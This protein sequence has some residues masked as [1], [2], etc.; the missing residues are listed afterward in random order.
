VVVEASLAGSNHGTIRRPPPEIEAAGSTILAHFSVRDTGI[1]IPKDKHEAVFNAF[2]QADNS[3]S[4]QFGGTGLGLAI[5]S[6]LIGQMGGHIWVESEAGHGSTFHFT[7]QFGVRDATSPSV[8]AAA[9]DKASASVAVVSAPSLP[10]PPLRILLAEDNPVNQELM[11]C[12]LQAH[13][14]NVTIANNG[15]EAVVVAQ[16][17]PFDLVLMDVQMPEMDGFE[18]TA[19][20]RANEAASHLHLPIIAMT[21][22]ALPSDRARCLAA[23]MDEYVAKPVTSRAL[24]DVIARCLESASPADKRGELLTEGVQS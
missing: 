18:A 11:L 2:E 14:H 12:M 4:R 5:A 9:P 1:G 22:N 13:G 10:L 8:V 15:R 23:G 16:R 7:A 24:F 20:I 19:A 6:R 17:Y 3:H 21:A